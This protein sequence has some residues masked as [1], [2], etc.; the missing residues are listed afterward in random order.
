MTGTTAGFAL[1]PTFSSSRRLARERA[2]S[3][4][5]RAHEQR[6]LFAEHRKPQLLTVR[7]REPAARESRVVPGEQAPHDLPRLADRRDRAATHRAR[8]GRASVPR[9]SPR[10]ARPC[11]AA[12]SAAVCPASSTGCDGERVEARRP[13]PHARGRARDLEQRGQ[14]RLEPEVVERGDDVEAGVLGE[15]RERPVVA[16]PLVRLQPEPELPRRSR[17]VFSAQHPLAGPLDPHHDA[18]VGVGTADE[19]VLLEPV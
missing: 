8:A 9:A 18:L 3:R 1:P 6:N 17:Q 2:R 13:E 15:S 11:E 19:R 14:R 12:S 5:P 4:R 7:Q 10:K 16:G